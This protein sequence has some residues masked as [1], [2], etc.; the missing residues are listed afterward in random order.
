MALDSIG[1]D[2][3]LKLSSI[4][5]TTGIDNSANINLTANKPAATD[6]S[7]KKDGT[8]LNP[9]KGKIPASGSMF[10]SS[11]NPVSQNVNTVIQQYSGDKKQLQAFSKSL[12]TLD[13]SKDLSSISD[14]TVNEMANL[15][16]DVSSDHGKIVI[17]DI[18]SGKEIN[19]DD[20]IKMRATITN[21]LN[22]AIANVDNV[23]SAKNSTTAVG[24]VS[25]ASS[26]SP[27][28][29]VS[30]PAPTTE[31]KANA[32]MS[33]QQQTQ[34]LDVLKGYSDTT[35]HV[36]EVS[37]PLK[38]KLDKS[39]KEYD[40]KVLE[41]ENQSKKIDGSISEI[42]ALKKG[43]EALIDKSKTQ[44][45]SVTE[46]K[47]LQSFA[48]TIALKQKDLV[49][50]QKGNEVLMGQIDQV[51]SQFSNDLSPT[52]KDTKDA[53]QI[54]IKAKI[55]G[56]S[57]TVR[58][59]F[60]ASI[61]EDIYKLTANMSPE[62]LQ[63]TMDDPSARVKMMSPVNKLL[64][65]LSGAKAKSDLSQQD[66]DTLQSK[67]HIKAVDENGKL[68]LYYSTDEKSTP[69]K[70]SK[71]DLRSLRTDLNNVVSSPHLFTLARASGQIALAYDT[72]IG[73]RA[74]E[75]IAD[76]TVDTTTTKTKV[77]TDKTES[78]SV[79]SKDN[80]DKVSPLSADYDA[81][82]KATQQIQRSQLDK[83][84][85]SKREEESYHEKQINHIH[86]SRKESEK[87][88]DQKRTAE[89]EARLNKIKLD[90]LAH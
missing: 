5:P 47:Q 29:S 90:N 21:T 49:T 22:R 43:A 79:T 71:D 10:G 70:V 36:D 42:L 58:Q 66:I 15:G 75:A 73:A 3:S 1:S 35:K 44:P 77:T 14:E 33:T 45:L 41:A 23:A 37:N 78:I 19:I 11:D 25:S 39:I 2:S 27:V 89:D 28:K 61:S 72:T 59:N 50:N 85:E 51:Y 86:E 56:Q 74:K 20:F 9:S 7:I 48:S 63:K 60:L 4:K 69:Q 54:A 13:L 26:N 64:D 82:Q 80:K 62:E 6:I 55:S 8:S 30:A 87:Y 34:M 52:E 88:L 40:A 12:S 53:M 31:I 46:K 76:K 24:S 57:L 38:V 18:N 16:F 17:K 81:N 65:K 83:S 84:I 68:E 67:F 32:Q